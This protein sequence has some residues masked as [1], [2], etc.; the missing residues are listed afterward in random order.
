MKL[1]T[2]SCIK[3]AVMDVAF[4]MN[5]DMYIIFNSRKINSTLLNVYFSNYTLSQI[6]IYVDIFPCK[7]REAYK[8]K[9]KHSFV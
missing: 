1:E 2:L 8:K 6:K 5:A 7:K 9:C 3:M 4:L